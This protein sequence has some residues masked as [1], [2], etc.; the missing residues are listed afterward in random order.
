MQDDAMTAEEKLE[1]LANQE[2][3]MFNAKLT[4]HNQNEGTE[5]ARPDEEM[6]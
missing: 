2:A 3:M 4:H 1:E 6:A 5:K